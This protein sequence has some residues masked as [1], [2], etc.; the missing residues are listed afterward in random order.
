MLWS[1]VALVLAFRAGATGISAEI[2]FSAA[3]MAQIVAVVETSYAMAYRDELTQLPSRRALN[4]ALLQLG[5][6]YSIAM[7]DVDHFKK[8]NDTFGHDSGDH[9]LR[10]VASKLA[11]VTGGGKAYRYGGEE[12]AVVFPGKSIA[13]SAV[14]VDKL[15]RVIEHTSFVVRGKERRTVRDNGWRNGETETSVTVS[16]GVAAS[17]EGRTDPADVMESADKALY[18]A[19]AKGRNCT[20]AAGRKRAV[21]AMAS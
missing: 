3:G 17:G 5:Q 12:F 6:S 13:E 7:L 8:F 20:V 15:R 4:E 1:L 11:Q 21:P 18:R 19:K 9:A 16:V 2:Y 10:M 14:A